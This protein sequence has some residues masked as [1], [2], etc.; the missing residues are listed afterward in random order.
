MYFWNTKELKQELKA[1][2]ITENRAF[3]YFLAV[4]IVD[5]LAMATLEVFHSDT[6]LGAWDYIET[7]GYFTIVVGGTIFLYHR[8]GGAAGR[9]FFARYFSILWVVGIRFFALSVPLLAIW[10]AT[11][12]EDDHSTRTTWYEAVVYLSFMIIY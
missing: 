6:E 3:P 11:L 4:L 12:S 10:L 5:T 2:K 1:G 9:E 8:N 7:F